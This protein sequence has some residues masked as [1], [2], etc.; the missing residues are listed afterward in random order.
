MTMKKKRRIKLRIKNLVSFIIAIVLFGYVSFG[1]INY[2][3]SKKK[4]ELEEQNLEQK[5]YE[6]K[7]KETDLNQEISKLKDDDYLARYAREEY[8]YSKDGE[9]VI[10]IEENES[11]ENEEK[12]EPVKIPEYIILLNVLIVGVI[13]ASVTLF[14]L[15][16][17]KIKKMPHKMK[18]VS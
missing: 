15:K 6:L 17:K 12:V 5:L 10:K 13:I 11:S 1:V 3:I 9:Y 4:F 2:N 16:N 18:L 14:I 8:L 7:D